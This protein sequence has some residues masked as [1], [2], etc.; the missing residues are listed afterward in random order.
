MCPIPLYPNIPAIIAIKKA[1]P[2][3]YKEWKQRSIYINNREKPLI[4]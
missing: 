1:N 2:C 3:F 4:N